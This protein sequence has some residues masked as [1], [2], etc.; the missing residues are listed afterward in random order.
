MLRSLLPFLSDPWYP[1]SGCSGY[2]IALR[3]LRDITLC[4]NPY[5][6]N[7]CIGGHNSK[8]PELKTAITELASQFPELQPPILTQ[9]K[10]AQAIDLLTKDE[11]GYIDQ[12]FPVFDKEAG[13]CDVLIRV[14]IG[15]QCQSYQRKNER[16]DALCAGLCLFGGEM[17]FGR[18]VRFYQ[19]VAKDINAW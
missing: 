9:D 1:H 16:I 17:K 3:C 8:L 18:M 19:S 2:T 12:G 14:L 10:L 15:V 11:S 4:L 7:I 13:L 5:F 6:T